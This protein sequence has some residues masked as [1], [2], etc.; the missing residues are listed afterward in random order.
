MI[1]YTNI[2]NLSGLRKGASNDQIVLTQNQID[3]QFPVN[4]ISLLQFSNGFLLSNGL[5]IYSAEDIIER[6]T[7]YEVH[8]YCPEH[9]LIGDDSGGIGF[10]LSRDKNDSKIY[11]S[12]LG[13]LYP[14][15]FRVVS[16]DIQ[17]WIDS[18]FLAD[19]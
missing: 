16:S 6:N 9:F 3:F 13:D 5:N 2:L 17:A 18:E 1:N 12:G 7:T 15:E 14:P 19:L 11:R 8:E 4:Y 10:L